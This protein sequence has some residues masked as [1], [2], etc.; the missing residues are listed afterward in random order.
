MCTCVPL[1]C[2]TSEEPREGHWSLGNG[3]TDHCE[4]PWWGWE[5]NP[6]LLWEQPSCCWT[7][8]PTPESMRYFHWYR[9]AGLF[10]GIWDP[11]N[12]ICDWKI[13]LAPSTLKKYIANFSF[14]LTRRAHTDVDPALLPGF[15]WWAEN[16]AG[17]Q[18]YLSSS[19]FPNVPAI[20]LLHGLCR[21]T[22]GIFT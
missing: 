7:I 4:L 17:K 20:I 19:P 8:S 5:M 12:D 15:W 18:S 9:R 6:S 13:Y 10:K 21:K 1:A 11:E 22:A 16:P 2:L 3:V 14:F